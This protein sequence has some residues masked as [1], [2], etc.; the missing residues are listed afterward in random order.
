M[1]TYKPFGLWAKLD[2]L[3]EPVAHLVDKAL[4][5]VVPEVEIHDRLGCPTAKDLG[6]S[7]AKVRRSAGAEQG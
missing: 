7:G 1:G 6:L 3:S 4:S 5:I 2:S